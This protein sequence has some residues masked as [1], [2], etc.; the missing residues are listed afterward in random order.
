MVRTP[1]GEGGYTELPT[2]LATNVPAAIE[3][4]TARDVERRVGNTIA[5]TVSHIVTIRYLQGVS[6]GTQVVFGARRLYVRGV[7]NPEEKNEQLVLA[8]EE[9]SQL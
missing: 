1:D 8:C 3:P 9:S 5:S 4:A 6:T 7:Q 2:V